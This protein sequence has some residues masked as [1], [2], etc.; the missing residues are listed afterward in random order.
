MASSKPKSGKRLAEFLKEQQDPFILDLY[1]LERG[2]STY[3][4]SA[5]NKKREPLFQFSKLLTTLHKKLLFHNPTCILIRES[6]I[7]NQHLLHTVPRQPESTDQTIED[8]DRFSSSTATNSTLYLSC[9]DSDE[10]GTALSPQKN[11]ALFFP[12]TCHASNTGIPQRYELR[13]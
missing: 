9:S 10:D 4:E 7:I 3:G 5:K 6:H 2:Y 11:K 8:T 1:L 12:N 13:F